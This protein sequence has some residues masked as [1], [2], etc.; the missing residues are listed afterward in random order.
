MSR[1]VRGRRERKE[2]SANESRLPQPN[3]LI[4]LPAFHFPSIISPLSSRVIP[5]H[6]NQGPD[7]LLLNRLG[8]KKGKILLFARYLPMKLLTLVPLLLLILPSFKVPRRCLTRR[9]SFKAVVF[10]SSSL[11]YR[12]FNIRVLLLVGSRDITSE[13][14][15]C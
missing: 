12:R 6:A 10:D 1:W 3:Y 14:C 13:S 5:S 2:G 4:A 9:R 15:S 8:G 11:I 7:R